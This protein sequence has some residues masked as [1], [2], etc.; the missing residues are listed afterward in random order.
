MSNRVPWVN[1]QDES[2]EGKVL[3]MIQSS[4]VAIRVRVWRV[5]RGISKE[6]ESDHGQR[7]LTRRQFDYQQ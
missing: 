4:S 2:K 7:V 1:S 3:T 6:I 5:E